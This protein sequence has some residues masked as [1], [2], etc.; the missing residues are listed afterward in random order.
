M[1]SRDPGSP[2]VTTGA[3][4]ALPDLLARVKASERP[5]EEL[6][7]LILCALAAPPGAFVAQSKINGAWCT[8]TASN[9][10]WEKSSRPGGW[11]R[12][13]GWALTASLD[14]ALALVERVLPGWLV[15]VNDLP[16][17]NPA[18]SAVACLRADAKADDVLGYG[19]TRPL[20]L[21]TAMLKALIATGS[22]EPAQVENPVPGITND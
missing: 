17:L 4:S 15:S 6:D 3:G 21:L 14:A 9:R 20:A 11:Y 1:T 5:S 7:A 22:A 16:P 2:N 10:L 18:G 12:R 19:N 13:D 8:Y